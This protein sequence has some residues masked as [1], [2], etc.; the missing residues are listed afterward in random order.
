MVNFIVGVVLGG[1]AMYIWHLFIMDKG[2]SEQFEN[3]AQLLK[4]GMEMGQANLK[5][6]TPKKK[7][8]K[9][10]KKKKK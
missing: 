9:Q 2:F 6:K 5:N 8:K 4:E 7:L 3:Q 1:A 10:I